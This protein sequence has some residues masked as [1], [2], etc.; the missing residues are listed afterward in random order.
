V[1]RSFNPDAKIIACSAHQKEL[2]NVA[3]LLNIHTFDTA[4]FAAQQKISSGQSNTYAE[5]VCVGVSL[6]TT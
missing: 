5:L 1:L 4:R 6:D 3:T 2:L